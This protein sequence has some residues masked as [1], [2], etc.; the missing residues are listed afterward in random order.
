M[1][2]TDYSGTQTSGIITTDGSY[3][4]ITYNSSGSFTG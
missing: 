3:T 2:T 4:I 1:L